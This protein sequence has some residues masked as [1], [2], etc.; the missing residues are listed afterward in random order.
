MEPPDR[1]PL[2]RLWNA[3]VAKGDI[4]VELDPFDIQAYMIVSYSDLE[5]PHPTVTCYVGLED[6]S[7]EIN[8][9]R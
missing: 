3:R 5:A 8:Q 1:A 6:S 7:K 9:Y 4:A 2:I